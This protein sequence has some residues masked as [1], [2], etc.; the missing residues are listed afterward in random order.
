MENS[1]TKKW[2]KWKKWKKNMIYINK[3][4]IK[5][6]ESMKRKKHIHMNQS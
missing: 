5:Y 1:T 4:N 6:I 2:K 3:A